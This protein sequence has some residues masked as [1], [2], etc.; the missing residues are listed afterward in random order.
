MTIVETINADFISAMKQKDE[1]E[2]STLR[3]VRSALK[4]KE[5]DLSRALEDADA[6][7]VLK[8]MKKQYEDALK[9]FIKGNR[10][11]LV[12]KQQKEIAIVSRYLPAGMPEAEVE[13]IV[14][15]QIAALGA[16]SPDDVGK[17]MGPS[18]KALA[19]GADGN[20]VRE[21]ATRSLSAA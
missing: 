21:I 14:R 11:D 18:M 1:L 8:S 5:I 6:L 7:A 15:E 2:L 4:N 20:L 9:D 12:E 16:T 10:A 19:G 13:R 3:L 17:V